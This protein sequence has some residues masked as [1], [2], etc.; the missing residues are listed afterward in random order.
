P[1]VAPPVLSARVEC[2]SRSDPAATAA[3]GSTGGASSL[4]SDMWL[5]LT[6]A[7]TSDT[8]PVAAMP[9]PRGGGLDS[10]EVVNHVAE[11][12]A[13]V[14]AGRVMV[15]AEMPP[16][17]ND[18]GQ[19]THGPPASKRK[20]LKKARPLLFDTSDADRS[21]APPTSRPP[22]EAVPPCESTL[23]PTTCESET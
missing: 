14:P 7:L 1:S 13:I 19:S 3:P 21:S 6:V 4:S 8:A 12:L 11:L 5:S 18:T 17:L 2:S 9:P 15:A 23:L 16:P 10:T 22:P 20:P